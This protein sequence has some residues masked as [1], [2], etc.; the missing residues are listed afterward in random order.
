MIVS[1]SYQETK[2]VVVMNKVDYVNKLQAMINEGIDQGVYKHSDDNTLI[3]LKRFQD[4]LYR[5]FRK[6]E[7]YEK[8]RPTSNAPAKL[9]GTAKTHKFTNISDITVESIKFRPIITQTGTCMY[10]AAQVI[11]QYLKP[12]YACNDYIINNTQDFPEMIRNQSPITLDEEYVSY[13][14]E[15]LFTN[16][17]INDTVDYILDQIYV[18]KKLPILCTRLVMKRLLLKLSADSTFIFQSCFFKQTDGCTMGGPLSVTLA[19]I[20]LTKMETE[21]VKSIKPPFYKR[22]VDNIITRRKINEPDYLFQS[23]NSYH[24]NIRFTIETQPTKF[25][26]TDITLINGQVITSVHRKQNKHPTHWSSKIPKR[27]KRNT[28]NGDLNRSYR[29]SNNYNKEKEIIR[30]KFREAGYPIRFTESV[31]KDFETK[32]TNDC[33]IP[34]FLFKEKRK[35]ILI[36]VPFSDTNEQLAKRFIEKLKFFTNDKID[37]AIKWA[38]KKVKQLFNSKDKNPHP[39]CKIYEGTCSCG[40]N[41]IGETQRNVETR[42]SELT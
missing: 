38:T 40:L 11:S 23:M 3:D 12:L 5:N 13:D 19:N 6:Y 24:R 22:Y 36:E 32:L 1:L 7:H 10:N 27:Y 21:I 41:Y 34:D 30:E 4:F 42:W 8:M 16:V 9:Y 26:D 17:P 37:F 39:A 14:V 2:T 31:I 29:I 35:F 18:H 28:I 25:L 20:F 15:S 33:I